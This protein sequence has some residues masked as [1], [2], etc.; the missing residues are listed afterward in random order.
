MCCHPRGAVKNCDVAPTN[1]P[2]PK[3]AFSTKRAKRQMKN[4]YDDNDN[5]KGN[6]IYDT[7][8]VICVVIPYLRHLCRK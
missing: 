2:P 1:T 4:N 8:V 5:N 6:A 3:T 7:G